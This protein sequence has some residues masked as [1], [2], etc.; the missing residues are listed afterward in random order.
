MFNNKV[1][2]AL[3]TP[4]EGHPTL[5][6]TV[7]GWAQVEATQVGVAQVEATQV[8][9]TQVGVAQVE[10]TQVA[11]YQGFQEGCMSIDL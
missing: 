1:L 4:Y 10:A 7:N 5:H 2:V 9:A 11:P 6:R 8:E 3:S